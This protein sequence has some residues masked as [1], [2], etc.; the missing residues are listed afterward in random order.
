VGRRQAETTAVPV[1]GARGYAR[2]MTALQPGTDALRALWA[3]D[4]SVDF[5]NHGSF[6]ATPRRVL[7]AQRRWRDEME[8]EPVDFL[9]RRL[10]ALLAGVRAEVAAFL[11]GD[12]DGLVLV[13]NATTGVNTVLRAF[14]WVPGDE[15][16]LADSTY[17]AVKQAARSLADR[18]GVRV[19]EARVPFPLS[20]PAE[21]TAAFAA[22]MTERTR[23]V[24]VDHVVSA[25]AVVLPVEAIVA[26]ARARGI[27][28][29]VDG[30][31]AP[32]LL[33]LSLR[34]V[35]ADFYTGNLHKWVCTPKGAA[36]LHVGPAWRG[37]LHPLPVSHA[38]GAGLGAEF[39][40]TG[41][42]DPSAW[43]AVPD[44]LALFGE[45]GWDAIR[46]ANH[47]LVRAGREIVAD[48]L[49]SAL[50]HPDDPR[51]YGP[52]ATIRVPWADPA[53]DRKLAALGARLFAEHRVEVPFTR[54]DGRAWV[55]ISGQ[56]YNRPEQYERLAAI[57]RAWRG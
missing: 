36:V 50:P 20:E 35:D 6:G 42:A 28:T 40:W 47:A 56:L 26:T 38:Y 7:A 14:D 37:R 55:R 5:L 19:V 52:M 27:A 21:V 46:A 45:M 10:P 48:A 22:A 43:L 57:L 23:L 41:T 3:L 39:D 34:A 25:T 1:A 16:L 15:L 18:Y 33:P 32:G 53:D 17:N 2:A 4:P 29:L 9:A 44:A 51:L 30:A 31:H 8:A 11:D 54:Y 49:G 13:P 12:A 24:V